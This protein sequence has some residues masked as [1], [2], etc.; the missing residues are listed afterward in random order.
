M[1]S[2]PVCETACSDD[3]SE[4]ANCG[5]VLMLEG[6]LEVESETVEGLEATIL[7]PLDSVTGVVVRIAE[8]EDTQLA[9]PKMVVAVEALQVDRSKQEELASAQQFWFGGLEDMESG[10]EQDGI[11]KTAAPVD[12]GVCAWCQAPGTG[13]ICD[14]CGRRRLRGRTSAPRAVAGPGGPLTARQRTEAEENTV[15]CPGCLSRVP[16]TDR[17]PE[18][19]TPLP[20]EELF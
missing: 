8:V 16:R 18:C 2:C 13:V 6:E 4:C 10:R 19:K 17:C 20:R 14:A 9:D 3:A 5:K 11:P 7:D 1:P 12:T 15:L